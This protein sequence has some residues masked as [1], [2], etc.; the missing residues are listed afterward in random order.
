M[1]HRIAGKESRRFDVER[2]VKQGDP[3]S[4]LLFLAVM[5][6]IFR[7]LKRRWHGLNTR[8]SKQYYG[9]V[10][11][12]M[13]NPLANLRFAD[14][15]LLVAASRADIARMISDLGKEASRYGLKLHMGKTRVLA[16]HITE[17]PVQKVLCGTQEVKVLSLDEAEKYLGRKLAIN[18]YHATELSNRIA[19]G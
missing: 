13:H 15:V 10:I 14:D 2:G 17:T 6:V 9:M 5:E 4:S 8:R 16:N 18:Q 1:C 12:S 7:R 19:S 3:I 11:D